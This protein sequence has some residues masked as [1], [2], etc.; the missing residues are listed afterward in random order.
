MTNIINYE[1]EHQPH[2]KSLNFDWLNKYFKVEEIDETVLT[3]PE[4]EIIEK[5]GK[6][7]CAQKDEKIIGTVALINRETHYELSKM[8][9]SPHYQNQGVGTLLMKNILD[10]ARANNIK[11][12]ILYSHSKLKP[13][14]ALYENFGFEYVSVKNHL[15]SRADIVM[16]INL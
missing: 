7:L 2:F 8:A 3:Y 14:L 1:S 12:I 15:Y 16:E 4:K 10:L 5:G 6:I 13:A 11:H 9:V